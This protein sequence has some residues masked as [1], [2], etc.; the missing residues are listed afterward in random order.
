MA[1]QIISNTISPSRRRM[2][3]ELRSTSFWSGKEEQLRVRILSRVKIPDGT[4]EEL[5]RQVIDRKEEWVQNRKSMSLALN[6][7]NANAFI[8]DHQTSEA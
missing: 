2:D 5:F 7:I 4:E 6:G 1:L 8:L 3:A